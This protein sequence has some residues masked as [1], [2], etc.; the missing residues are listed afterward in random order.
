METLRTRFLKMP[1]TVTTTPLSP[2]AQAETS[3]RLAALTIRPTSQSLMPAPFE[4][5]YIPSGTV[6]L[7][8]RADAQYPQSHTLPAYDISKYPITN[9]QFAT[10]VAAKGYDNPDWWTE[11]GWQARQAYDWTQPLLRE[12]ARWNG[13]DLPVVGV[14]WHEAVAFCK[15]LSA[16]TGEAIHLPSEAQWQRAAQ[17]LPDGTDSERLYPWGDEWDSAACNN[18]VTHESQHTTPVTQFPQGASPCGVWDL[19]GNV[20]EWCVDRDTFSEGDHSAADTQMMRGAY[21]SNDNP[22]YFAVTYPNWN[23][24]D[25]RDNY[26]GFRVVRTL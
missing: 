15:W 5:A 18:S 2:E 17:A 24:V 8:F 14:S 19:C 21:W 9:A 1:I 20:W 12:D 7:H 4:W 23:Q 16:M 10:F 3:R 25:D 6:W 22:D 11:H 26:V 13:A